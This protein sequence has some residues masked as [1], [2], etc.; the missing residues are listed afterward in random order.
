M[1]RAPGSTHLPLTY[2]G[3]PDLDHGGWL[4]FLAL[5]S[6]KT[7]LAALSSS[8]RLTFRHDSKSRSYLGAKPI[9]DHWLASH[10]LVTARNCDCRVIPLLSQEH[11]RTD[12][13]LL[14]FEQS[15]P[16]SSR[17]TGVQDANGMVDRS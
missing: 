14:A 16:C 8:Q 17:I 7:T 1:M 4:V 13:P 3:G 12:L 2:R 9:A 6:P 15:V 11:V 5:L 10:E